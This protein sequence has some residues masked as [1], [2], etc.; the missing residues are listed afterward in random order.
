MMLNQNI[1]PLLNIWL[2]TK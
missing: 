2:W 1:M